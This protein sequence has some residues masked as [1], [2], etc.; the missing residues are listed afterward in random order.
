MK[1]SRM[2]YILFAA[3]CALMLWLLFD[4]PGH[5]DGIP[6]WDQLLPNLNLMP[7][8]T[9]RLFFG[10]LGDHRPY[11]VRTALINLLG[12]VVMFV[13]LGLFLP[14]LFPRLRKLWRAMLTASL[15]IAAVEIT[16]LFTLLGS[17]DVDDLILNLA[18]AAVG[19]GIY[20]LSKK[21]DC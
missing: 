10:L 18:G 11:L 1:R 16:Q 19:Y 8:R 5:I 15:L 6:Y 20:Q 7:F 21:P 13:P 2:T 14:L 9:L 3:Y 12:N 17:C 4:R